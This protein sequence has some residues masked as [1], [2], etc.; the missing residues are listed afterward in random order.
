MAEAF[1]HLAKRVHYF[2]LALAGDPPTYMA[3]ES[4]RHAATIDFVLL[5]QV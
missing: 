3:F 5:D 2:Y 4:R 1:G